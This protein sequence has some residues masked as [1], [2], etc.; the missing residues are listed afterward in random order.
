MLGVFLFLSETFTGDTYIVYPHDD[1]LYIH[2]VFV[3][4]QYHIVFTAR[5]KNDA[6]LA[7]QHI[8]G[9]TS[10]NTYEVVIGGGGNTRAII[11][12]GLFG[13]EVANEYIDGLLS[14]N[15]DRYGSATS[16]H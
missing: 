3:T 1:H 8:P 12:K 11:R 6:L 4:T 2:N 16:L 10:T 7:L 13:P 5:G 9:E 15:E 14:E